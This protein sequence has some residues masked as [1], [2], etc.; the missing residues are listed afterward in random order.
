MPRKF[1]PPLPGLKLFCLWLASA[2]VALAQS[3][4]SAPAKLLVRNAYILTMAK[5]QKEPFKG[6]L[7]VGSDGRLQTVAA[8]DPPANLQAKETLDAGGHWVIPGFISA[9]SHLWQS[10]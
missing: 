9:H 6:Y 8:G 3:P 4:A 1:F 2:S 5:D 10:A 7:V